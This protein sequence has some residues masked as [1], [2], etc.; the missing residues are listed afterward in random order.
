MSKKPKLVALKDSSGKFLGYR[1]SRNTELLGEISRF[2][3][4]DPCIQLHR[5]PEGDYC[6]RIVTTDKRFNQHVEWQ[7]VTADDAARWFIENGVRNGRL[8]ECLADVAERQI[9]RGTKAG[10]AFRRVMETDPETRAGW[11]RARARLQTFA[12]ATS[13]QQSEPTNAQ[14]AATPKRRG[15]KKADYETVQKEA[16]LAADWERARD[17]GIYK[18]D[19]AK[20]KGMTV[21]QLDT[22]LDRVAKRKRDS[23]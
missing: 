5:F 11:E 7:L 20:D 9:V 2:D 6:L 19:F 21:K 8:P 23:E 14:G 17:A 3:P 15:R 4:T 22:L 10:E 1:D 18:P 16:A 12:K 13:G